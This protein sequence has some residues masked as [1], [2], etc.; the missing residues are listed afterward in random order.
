MNNYSSMI[1]LLAY[2]YACEHPTK[3]DVLTI[4]P[5]FHVIKHMHFVS[6]Q[7]QNLYLKK[8]NVRCPQINMN[9]CIQ[10]HKQVHGIYIPNKRSMSS[11]LIVCNHS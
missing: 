2:Q 5:Y 1:L 9:S 4:L 7:E 3:V 6:P 10:V 11:C 8:Q